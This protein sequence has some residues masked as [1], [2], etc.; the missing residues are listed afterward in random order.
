MDDD[1]DYIPDDNEEDIY[2][3]EKQIY[4]PPRMIQGKEDEIH[5]FV[6]AGYGLLNTRAEGKMDKLIQKINLINRTDEERLRDDV[7]IIVTSAEIPRENA[8]EMLKYINYIPDIKFKSPAG[9]LFG[10]MIKDYIESNKLSDKNVKKIMNKALS[11]KDI[12]GQKTFII[13]ELDVIRYAR[14]WNE[15][16]K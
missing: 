1:F 5:Y 6:E 8:N 13:N 4:L 9:L 2:E 7:N 15:W 14:A 3:D 10:F 11:L 16:M 12:K